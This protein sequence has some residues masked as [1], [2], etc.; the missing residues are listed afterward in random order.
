MRGILI[1]LL[2]VG[3]ILFGCTGTTKEQQDAADKFVSSSEPT[4]TVDMGDAASIKPSVKATEASTPATATPR[5]GGENSGLALCTGAPREWKIEY[6]IESDAGGQKTTSKMTQFYKGQKKIRSDFAT[7]GIE[8]RS[9]LLGSE[10]YSCTQVSGSWSCSKIE[11]PAGS[12][13]EG[14]IAR[15]APTYVEDGTIS[16]AETTAN[17]WKGNVGYSEIRYCISSDCLP[18]YIATKGSSSGMTVETVTKATSFAKSVADSDFELPAAPG[19]G[20]PGMPGGA[21]G[22]SPAGGDS[23]AYCNYLTGEQKDAC[24]ASC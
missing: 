22:T 5:S 13:T 14:Q 7:S 16:V 15:D 21:D 11:K 4:K 2:F 1:G 6:A 18:L 10:Y 24:L 23:C 20:L 8:A 3:L 17:C 9:Y 19:S 12:D